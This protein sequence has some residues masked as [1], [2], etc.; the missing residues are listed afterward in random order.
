MTIERKKPHVFGV[1]SFNY[2]LIEELYKNF[3]S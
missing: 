2:M 1:F 3:K